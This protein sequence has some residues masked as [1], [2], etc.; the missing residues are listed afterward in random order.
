MASKIDLAQRHDKFLS[1]LLASP[2]VAEAA[3]TAGIG[4]RTA[5]RYLGDQEFKE[6]YAEA[7]REA[8]NLAISKL[9][10]AM[11]EAVG[12]LRAILSGA[13]A[14]P[15]ARVAAARTLLDLGLKATE[16]DDLSARVA[17]LEKEIN[18]F[19]SACAA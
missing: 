3:R 15:S 19:S 10:A 1:A 5:Y 16:T 11:S 12:A 13:E 18:K 14:S 9:Q 4:L 17:A 8:V 6:R 2:D 7:R